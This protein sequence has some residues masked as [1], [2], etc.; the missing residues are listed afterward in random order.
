VFESGI[1]SRVDLDKERKNLMLAK[2]SELNEVKLNM[3]NKFLR[4]L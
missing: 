3:F 2:K 4:D 1:F